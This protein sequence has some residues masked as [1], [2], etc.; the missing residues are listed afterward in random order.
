M[1]AKLGAE[2]LKHYSPDDDNSNQAFNL[3]EPSFSDTEKENDGEFIVSRKLFSWFNSFS[4]SAL[5]CF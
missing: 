4:L 5:N 1:G 3:P 2:I